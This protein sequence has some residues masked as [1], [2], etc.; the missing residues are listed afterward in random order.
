M[1]PLLKAYMKNAINKKEGIGFVLQARTGSTRL[2]GK[3][4]LPFYKGQG[5]L[6]LLLRRLKENFEDLPIVVATSDSPAD[7]AIATLGERLQVAVFRGSEHNVL[8]RFVQAAASQ[9]IEHIMRI[10]ADN[11]FLE[12]GYMRQ[13]MDRWTEDMDYLSYRTPT[14]IPAI[15]T[16]FGFFTEMVRLTALKSVTQLTRDTLYLEHVTNFI[17]GNPDRFSV[18][19][20]ENE[21]LSK[22]GYRLTV[23]TSDDFENAQKIY[24][25]IH[26]NYGAQWSIKEILGFIDG[27][28]ALKASMQ[29]QIALNSK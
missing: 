10:C 22:G 11:P 5:I 19:F 12:T 7:D 6:E 21:L 4:L 26:D 25:Y 16:H 18:H 15:K 29:Y 13:L 9:G 14:G 2:P 24:H 20:V 8:D 23:D 27:Q 3:I 28:E 1:K 17:Y